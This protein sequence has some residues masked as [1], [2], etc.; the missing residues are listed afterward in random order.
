MQQAL[1]LIAREGSGRLFSIRRADPPFLALQEKIL[2]R[3]Q[4]TC[5]FC[6]FRTRLY[7]EIVNID[8][9]FRRNQA[10]NLAAACP[11]CTQCF[12]LEE[13]GKTD[14]TGG[15]LIHAPEMSQGQV[16]ALCHQLF[17]SMVSNGL[18][19]TESRTLYRSLKGRS[20]RVEKVVGEGLSNP[21]RYGRLLIEANSE[22]SRA[23]HHKICQHVRL[24]PDF[25]NFSARVVAWMEEGIQAM[26][27][28]T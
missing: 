5:Q 1:P 21:A 27:A 16:N 28:L 26:T 25:M 4:S 18:C 10:S 11:F 17:L 3:D 7:L 6:G 8:G 24:L 20:Q 19:A 9:D 22:G 14:A 13:I 2:L 23:L 15:V 12:F